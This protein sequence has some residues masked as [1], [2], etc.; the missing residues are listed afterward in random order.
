MSEPA[1]VIAIDGLAGS[2]KGTIAKTL[3][4][5]LGWHWLDSGSLYRITALT[6]INHAVDLNSDPD[7]GRIAAS[8]NLEMQPPEPRLFL[9]GTDVTERIRDLDVSQGASLVS[10]HPQVRQA[11]LHYQHQA[12]RFPGLVAEGRDM[13]TVVFPDA[14]LKVFLTATLAERAR[15][16]QQ[17]LQELGIT[18]K[19]NRLTEDLEQRDRQ[20]TQRGNSPLVQAPDA[21]LIDTTTLSVEE[22][23]ATI[24][25]RL[26]GH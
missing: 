6:C 15:R 7:C 24:R 22:V 11:L 18:A 14:E 23:C 25:A 1:P 9:D 4:S 13:G 21:C 12:R 5:Q 26:P 20:D 17:Q 8:L 10:S 19:I 2:G 3:A 16:R